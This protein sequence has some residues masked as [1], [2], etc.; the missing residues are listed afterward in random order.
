MALSRLLPRL[1]PRPEPVPE[2]EP[3]APSD[4]VAKQEDHA[5]DLEP[6][7][8]AEF[9]TERHQ[10]LIGIV[11]AHLKRLGYPDDKDEDDGQ[12]VKRLADVA[13]LAAVSEIGTTSDLDTGELS[14]VAD[15]LS[16]CK[17]RKALDV[18]LG[19]ARKAGDDGA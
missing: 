7:E 18:L 2:D 13:T 8:A 19:E 4:E 11:W 15:T 5:A 9:G 16:R 3:D 6:G 14:L 10:K 12:R 1:Q 17:N